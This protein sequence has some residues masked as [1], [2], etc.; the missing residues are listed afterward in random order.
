MYCRTVGRTQGTLLVAAGRLVRAHR[1]L[2]ALLEGGAA[3]GGVARNALAAAL[4]REPGPVA[5]AV[6]VGRNLDSF[7]YISRG[8]YCIFRSSAPPPLLRLILFIFVCESE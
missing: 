7:L 1:A 5:L 4:G 8:V 3:L 6:V 2:L